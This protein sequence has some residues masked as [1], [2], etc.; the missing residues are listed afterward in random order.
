MNE[1]AINEI[2]PGYFVAQKKTFPKV[3]IN[4]GE[5]R[6]RLLVSRAQKKL[7]LL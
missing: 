3:Y 2:K 4:K 7:L 5:T 1:I 6:V